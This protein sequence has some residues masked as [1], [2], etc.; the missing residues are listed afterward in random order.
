M[1]VFIVLLV[2]GLLRSTSAMAEGLCSDGDLDEP[3]TYK[4]GNYIIAGVFGIGK[5]SVAT[6]ESEK[7]PVGTEYC[8][9]E[10]TNVYGLQKAIALRKVVLELEA[11]VFKPMNLSLGYAVYDSC[12]SAAITGR[13]SRKISLNE[14]VIGVCGVDNADLVKVSAYYTTG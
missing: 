11:K 8:D 5:L 3:L 9:Y 12:E 14:K 4:E 10:D 7:W 6:N 2:H 13:V 1:F